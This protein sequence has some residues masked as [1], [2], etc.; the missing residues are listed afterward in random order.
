M[1]LT[2]VAAAVARLRPETPPGSGITLFDSLYAPGWTANAGVNALVQ[3]ALSKPAVSATILDDG[4][5]DAALGTRVRRV[6]DRTDA[7]NGASVAQRHEYSRRQAYNCDS[8]LR[9][10]QSTPG[11]W[12]LYDAITLDKIERDNT[13]PSGVG[14]IAGMAGDCEP[15]WHPTNPNILWH[16]GQNG[17]LVWYER[18][19]LTGAVTTLFDM[20]PHM[21]AITGLTDVAKC[22]F[23]GEGRPSNDGRWWAFACETAGFTSRGF[24]MYDRQTNTVVGHLLNPT[25]NRPNWVGTSPLGNYA[26]LSWYGTSAA[27]LAAE[28]ALPIESAVGCR[29]YTQNFS[30]FRTL[31][32][33]GEHSDLCLDAYGNEVY[34]AI[35]YHGAANGVV[36]GAIFY[37]HIAAPE[38][39]Y[40]LPINAYAGSTGAAFHVSGCSMAKPGWAVIGKYN[41]VGTGP[42]DGQVIVAELVPTAP[43]IYRLAHHRST[44]AGG[45]FSEPHPTVNRDLTR[46]LFSTDWD[47][48]AYYED[49]EICLPSWVLP[50]AG[51]ASPAL[52]AA[53]TISG[54]STQG[55]T[56]TRVLGTYSGFPVP[57]IAGRWQV[58]TGSWADVSPAETGA[59]IVIPGGAANG[60]QYRWTETATNSGGTANGTSNVATVAALS[61]P[62]NTAPPTVPAT[63]FTGTALVAT[64]GSWSGNPVPTLSVR[65]QVNSG[66][67]ADVSPAETSYS[68][69][70][71]VAGTYRAM[72]TATN[73]Q[74]SAEQA[75][76]SSVVSYAPAE[77]VP[78]VVVNLTQSDG[79][80]LETIN[81]AW[82]NASTE[83]AVTSNAIQVLNG[84]VS[85]TAMMST[86]TAN[87]QAIQITR[88][89][90]GTSAFTQFAAAI[91]RTVPGSVGYVCIVSETQL[92]L[93][94]D[95]VQIGDT[96]THGVD[97]TTTA[98]TVK[99]TSFGGRVRVYTQGSG[100]PVL[101]YTDGAPLTGG[102]PGFWIYANGGLGNVRLSDI[103]HSA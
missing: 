8:T 30:S 53:P 64:A 47:G 27:S 56:L 103:R 10:A 49:Y 15:I 58:N 43:R 40:S 94:R 33:I 6:T 34:C 63:G 9:I 71:S 66:S 41:G 102:S 57:T 4:Y 46:V 87:D 88:A 70:P 13:N 31:Q 86:T 28:E 17:G 38:L 98:L 79:T 7:A 54:S 37:R 91:N 1:R 61:A 52:T 101:D 89:V 76:G 62:V 68:F 21:A 92:V 69:T 100:T 97:Q 65:W 59:S 14:S 19:V 55:G 84:Y 93:Q 18:N 45:Y 82:E 50:V 11:F 22:W 26:I 3:G 96:F 23:N 24:C 29:A 80:T 75:S 20:T 95:G 2:L 44:G 81:S 85:N 39:A 16:T 74:G 36:D 77:P 73:T 32:T 90:T 83:Y 99:V 25:G 12:W 48:G 60:T 35:S 5:T 51:T 78:S 42:Y 67:W 72:E